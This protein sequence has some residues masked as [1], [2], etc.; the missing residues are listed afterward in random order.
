MNA[1][2]AAGDR[3]AAVRHGRIHQSLVEDQ[4]GIPPDPAV[5]AL[6]QRLREAPAAPPRAPAPLPAAPLAE[7]GDPAAS[8]AGPTTSRGARRLPRQF[9]HVA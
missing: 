7:P 1:L 4:L 8:P 9:G 6:V 5:Q 3:A 2:A